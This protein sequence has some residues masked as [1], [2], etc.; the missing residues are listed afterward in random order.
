[1]IDIKDEIKNILTM[2][3]ILNKYN[4]SHS[5]TMFHCCFHKDKNASAKFYKN[6]FYCF[7]CNKTGDLIQFVQYLY[8]INFQEAIQKINIDF[9]L[10]LNIHS[11][12]DRKK[13]QEIENKKMQ[14]KIKKEKEKKHFIDLCDKYRKL[15]REIDYQ[16]KQV[17]IINWEDKVKEISKLQDKLY[18]IED[19][20]DDLY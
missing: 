10:N 18:L 19:E 13:I 14:E 8:N 12:I 4:I 2:E 16:L 11:K 15:R 6:S 9:N 20:L 3:D 5:K 7:S 17:N 1:M